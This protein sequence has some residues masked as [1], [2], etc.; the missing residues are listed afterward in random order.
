MRDRIK[1]E[2][3]KNV[4]AIV[5]E[6]AAHSFSSCAHSNDSDDAVLVPEEQPRKRRKTKSEIWEEEHPRGSD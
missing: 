1:D 6:I 3:G 2:S 5:I 4:S